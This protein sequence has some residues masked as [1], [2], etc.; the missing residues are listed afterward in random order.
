VP[1]YHTVFSKYFTSVYNAFYDDEGEFLPDL[2]TLVTG[3][4]SGYKG[5]YDDFNRRITTLIT[6]L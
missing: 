3:D 4:Y 6:Q 2:K 1:T 5:I